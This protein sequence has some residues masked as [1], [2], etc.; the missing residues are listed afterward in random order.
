MIR[1]NGLLQ[2]FMPL[3]KARPLLSSNNGQYATGNKSPFGPLNSG[4]KCE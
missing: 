1:K 2:R 3:E 4:K